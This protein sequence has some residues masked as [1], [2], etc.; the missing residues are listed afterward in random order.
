[1]VG[2]APLIQLVDGF[3]QARV[4]R[5]QCRSPL[6]GMRSQRQCPQ[7]LLARLAPQRVPSPET[8]IALDTEQLTRLVVRPTSL[9]HQLCAM[10]GWGRGA[11]CL[12]EH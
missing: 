8:A 6:A 1:M 9:C 5:L 12:L 4:Q 3:L 10:L 2:A 7:C 11:N